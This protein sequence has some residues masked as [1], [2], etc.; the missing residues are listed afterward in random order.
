MLLGFDPMGGGKGA[1][2]GMPYRRQEG[3]SGKGSKWDPKGFQLEATAYSCSSF[4][5]VD[6]L[7]LELDHA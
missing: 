3:P 1:K 4:V 7:C 5:R 6:R 2:S